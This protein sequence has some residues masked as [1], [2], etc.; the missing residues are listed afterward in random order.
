MALLILFNSITDWI[1]ASNRPDLI[2]KSQQNITK[3]YAVC[4]KH[5]PKDMFM[6]PLFRKL[7][8]GAVPVLVPPLLPSSKPKVQPFF[9]L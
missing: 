9:I 3:N 4:E 8:L 7:K 5:F 2:S 1:N 6:A